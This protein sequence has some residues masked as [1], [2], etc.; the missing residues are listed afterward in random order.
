MIDPA[1]VCLFIPGELARFKLN[2]FNRIGEHI[3]R[4]GGRT[5]RADHAALDKLPDDILPI[6][7]AAPYL[8]PLVRGWRARGRRWIG[9][10]RGYV[11]RVFATW[12]PRGENGGYYRW[13][14]NRYQMHSVRKVPADR[15]KALI[16]GNS[17]DPREIV[18][19]P[20]KPLGRH[21]VVAMPSPTY[22]RSH[23]GAETWLG[24]TL[25][26]LR[27]LTDRP[28]VVRDKE[29]KKPLQDDLRGAHC[30][31]AHGSMAAVESVILGCPVF[32]HPDS[33]AALVGR[34]DL[35]KIEDPIY[36]DRMAWLHSL[37]YCQ[38]SEP[39]LIDGTL[40]RLIE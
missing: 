13:H 40:W 2:L 15:W 18:L 10:D 32:V 27:S 23:D 19:H 17:V 35:S 26:Q 36:P 33:A 4:Q 21:I 22:S 31:V 5:I 38:F 24:Q 29:S 1:K 11:R 39:E 3:E 14:V 12:L 9:W 28:I 34:T 16:P 30:L 7:G 6:I 37:A 25:R 20:W 8:L